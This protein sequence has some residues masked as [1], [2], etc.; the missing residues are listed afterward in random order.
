MASRHPTPAARRVALTCAA[1]LTALFL[2]AC[3]RPLTG[4]DITAARL[5]ARVSTLASD[6]L[7]GRRTGTAGVAA[8]E[9][10]IAGAFR[11]EG[12]SFA[13]GRKS[14]FLDFNLYEYGFDRRATRLS[15]ET[16]NRSYRGVINRD[17][18][19]LP[20]SADGLVAGEVVFAGYGVS[21]PE[22][23][24]DDYDGLDVRG[25]IVLVFRYEPPRLYLQKPSGDYDYSKRA[26]FTTK[27]K[28]AARRGARAILF[29]T[30]PGG[31]PEGE[32]LLRSDSLLSLSSE[33]PDN[34]LFRADNDG[35]SRL[36]IPAFQLSVPF[37]DR[38][39]AAAGLAPS[40][41]I[42][43]LDNGA[44]AREYSLRGASALLACRRFF[45]PRPVRARDVAAFVPGS[46][47]ALADQWI[48]VAAHHDHIGTSPDT[49]DTV[50]NGA[51][52]N[53]SG[54]SGVVELARVLAGRSPR[55]KH[56][57][58]FLTFSGEEEGLLGSEALFDDGLVPRAAIRYMCN[59]DMIGR[60][61]GRVLQVLVR[62][63][64]GPLVGAARRFFA[65]RSPA[66]EVVYK[67]N[68]FYSDDYSFA[69]R[70]IPTFFFF[71]GLHD[72]YHGLKDEAD[73]LDYPAL[74][75]RVRLIYDFIVF[76]DGQP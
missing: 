47:P 41:V 48:V 19:P 55:L 29:A 67:R 43:G 2:T 50:Y 17:F 3:S 28:A 38:L 7:Q 64:D 11:G 31:D 65:G 9:E 30:G 10:Y 59:L 14:Y 74:E 32:K 63:D 16:G 68:D 54:V 15:L 66:A 23:G 69:E 21:A 12:L 35:E 8:A 24:Y 72:D 44:K 40:Q 52:D 53:A 4:D 22:A 76:L 1:A 34:P 60:N 75:K 45:P 58:L 46:D 42:A 6:A 37:G 71:S 13:P 27:T 5:E 70:K 25:K 62:R 33:R 57:L 26:Y 20:F 49:A 61:P 36:S 56:G 39:F 51:D 18:V 73:R